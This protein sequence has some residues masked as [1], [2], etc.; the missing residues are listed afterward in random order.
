MTVSQPKIIPFSFCKKGFAVLYEMGIK[1][2]QFYRKGGSIR[3]NTVFDG[4]GLDII[5]CLHSFQVGSDIHSA[6][7]KGVKVSN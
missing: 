1:L 3:E 7:R 2:G 5:F 6:Q 4:G